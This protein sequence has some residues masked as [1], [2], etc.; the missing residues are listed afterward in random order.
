MIPAVCRPIRS[1]RIKFHQMH[2]MAYNI[3]SGPELKCV[4]LQE[5]RQQVRCPQFNAVSRIGTYYQRFYLNF[6]RFHLTDI[7]FQVQARFQI[8]LPSR[9]VYLPYGRDRYPYTMRPELHFPQSSTLPAGHE[10]T[11]KS[12]YLRGNADTNGN[13]KS[14]RQL[15]GSGFLH[16]TKCPVYSIPADLS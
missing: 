14:H 10:F 9:T 12:T 13:E 2:M 7:G 4:C 15:P 5:L 8:L 3:R 6:L 16:H 1:N 11:I